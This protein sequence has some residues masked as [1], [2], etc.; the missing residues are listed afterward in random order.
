MKTPF[1]NIL[2]DFTLLRQNPKNYIYLL[3]FT[4]NQTVKL[5]P[6]NPVSGEIAREIINQIT[7]VKTGVKVEFVGSSALKLPGYKDIDLYIPSTKKNHKAIEASLITLFGEPVKQ[8]KMFSEWHMYK[9]RYR[10]ELML[11]QKTEKAYLEQKVVY[12]VLR[13]NPKILEEYKT[14]KLSSQGISKREYQ[15]RRM[16]FYNNLVEKNKKPFSLK[17][18]FLSGGRGVNSSPAT[19]KRRMSVAA[20]S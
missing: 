5:H 14:L 12:D 17:R 4:P 16:A 20:T 3:L 15:K 9:H 19:G 11:I 18:I 8:R 6:Y 1:K 7:N 10:I 2:R 13:K